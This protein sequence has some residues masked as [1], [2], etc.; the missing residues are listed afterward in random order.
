M[1]TG[2]CEARN[3]SL[4]NRGKAACPVDPSSAQSTSVGADGVVD[5]DLRCNVG[6]HFWPI[7]P[8]DRGVALGG[9]RER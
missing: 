2:D 1:W 4:A 8:V 9:E 7:F 5:A 3:Q 6:F